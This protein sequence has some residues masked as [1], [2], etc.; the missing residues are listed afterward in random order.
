MP[1]NTC[2]C[3]ADYNSLIAGHLQLSNGDTVESK[4]AFWHSYILLLASF[5]N[6]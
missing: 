3:I 5:S 4:L 1:R 2:I 6:K